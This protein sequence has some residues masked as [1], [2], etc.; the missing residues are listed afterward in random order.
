[1]KHKIY[2]FCWL[3][4]GWVAG[5]TGNNA[6]QTQNCWSLGWA[7]QYLIRKGIIIKLLLQC[8][9]YLCF[10]VPGSHETSNNILI[11][12]VRALCTQT[13][14]GICFKLCTQYCKELQQDVNRKKISLILLTCIFLSPC[15]L[16][17]SD[18]FDALDQ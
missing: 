4:G 10:W 13:V 1:M 2:Y 6:N 17:W 15:D 3:V 12:M 11:Y 7:W 5:P 9:L 18:M 14:E 8:S 16:F